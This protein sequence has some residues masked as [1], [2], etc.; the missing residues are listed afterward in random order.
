MVSIVNSS[1]PFGR[2]YVSEVLGA[3]HPLHKATIVTSQH[4]LS[5]NINSYKALLRAPSSLIAWPPYL[6]P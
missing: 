2:S 6:I 5:I 1:L 3:H 4:G